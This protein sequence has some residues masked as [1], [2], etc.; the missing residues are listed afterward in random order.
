MTERNYTMTLHPWGENPERG[1]VRIA[2]DELYGYWEHRDGT[3]GGGLWFEL[4][5]AGA[6]DLADYDGHAVLPGK[7]IDALRAA[8]VTVGDEFDFR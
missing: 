3:E 1:I 7:V 2:P 8:G 6:L 4:T 5:T